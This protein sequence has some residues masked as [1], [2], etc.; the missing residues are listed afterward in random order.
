MRSLRVRLPS[1]QMELIF[2]VPARHSMEDL[3]NLT[4]AQLVALIDQLE[5]FIHNASEND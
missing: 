2:I 1:V 4:N 5:N 3:K